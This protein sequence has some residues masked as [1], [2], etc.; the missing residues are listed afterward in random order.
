MFIREIGAY[1]PRVTSMPIIA[2]PLIQVA[3]VDLY[4]NDEVLAD[5]AVEKYSLNQGL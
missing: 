4:R 3:C 2:F 1:F 5:S